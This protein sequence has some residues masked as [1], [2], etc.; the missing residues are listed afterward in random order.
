M[1]LINKLTTRRRIK[2]NVRDADLE[3]LQAIFAGVAPK[4]YDRVNA[5]LK[6][7]LGFIAQDFEGTGVTGTTRREQ[8]S[9]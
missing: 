4:R 9:S 2:Q 5:D 1:N 7:C 8:S 3:E 6:D